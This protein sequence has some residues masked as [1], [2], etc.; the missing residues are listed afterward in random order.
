MNPTQDLTVEAVLQ[1]RANVLDLKLVSGSSGLA[2][3]I[4]TPE[5]TRPGLAFA[6]FYEVFSHDRVQILGNTEM[7]YLRSLSHEERQRR[8]A[9]TFRFKMPCIIITN[10][11]SVPD[12]ITKLSEEASIPVLVTSLPTTRLVSQLNGWLERVFAPVI[13]I[14]GDLLD[15]YG[16]GT[17]I[18]GGSGVGKSECALELIERGHRLVADD[19]CILRRM[20]KEDLVG[21]SSDMLKYHMEIRGLGILNIEML[22]GVAS[23]VDEKRLDL[24]VQL[25]KWDDTV[26]YERLGIDDRYHTIL[27]VEVPKY[28]IPVQP[29][30]NNSIMV[31]MAA[32]SQRL[33]NRGINPAL[34]MEAQLTNAMNSLM[35]GGKGPGLL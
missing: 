17:L 25:E 28:I 2:N 27:D 31:E 4:N 13:N 23:V 30:R 11:H 8:L 14:H 9:E 6:G 15:V 34:M 22:F 33:K 1:D 32:L 19:V 3:R 21:R 16:M 26:E 20:S 29:G 35:Q 7:S 18:L 24:I 5:L 10:G 12:E